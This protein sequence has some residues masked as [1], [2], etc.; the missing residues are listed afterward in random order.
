MSPSQNQS[1][2]AVLPFVNAAAEDSH[3]FDQIQRE[4]DLEYQLAQERQAHERTRI[5]LAEQTNASQRIANERQIEIALQAHPLNPKAAKMVATLLLKGD[6]GELEQG[7]NGKLR[8]RHSL[9]SLDEVAADYLKENPH[10]SASHGQRQRT[11]GSALDRATMT[12]K[13]IADYIDQHGQEKYL[14]LPYTKRALKK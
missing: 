6:G 10:F 14:A 4:V 13:Q 3:E 11:T 12:T 5:A 1:I 7:K 2:T 9:R 8:D